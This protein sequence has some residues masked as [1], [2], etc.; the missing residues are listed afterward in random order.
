M[1]SSVNLSSPA[2]NF[3]FNMG[4]GDAVIVAPEQPRPTRKTRSEPGPFKFGNWAKGSSIEIVRND[5]YWGDK[6][7]LASATFRII[8]DAAAATN[9]MLAGDV[10]AF[11]NFPAPEALP[12]IEADPRFAVVTG[13]T[14][15]ETI[16]STNNSKPP[17]NDIQGASGH[18]PHD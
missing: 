18:C 6:V 8:P 2:G 4:W 17:F 10:D 12:Q 3:L 5:A 16:L 7:A 11:A 14:E 9:A 15:G 1:L 13:S